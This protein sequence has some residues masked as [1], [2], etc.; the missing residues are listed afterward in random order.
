M[1]SLSAYFTK[2]GAVAVALALA[3]VGAVAFGENCPID[4]SSANFTG[5]TKVDSATGK[6]LKLYR[7]ARGHEFWVAG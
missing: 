7:C 4:N 3:A 5:T 1:S 2:Q 6:L